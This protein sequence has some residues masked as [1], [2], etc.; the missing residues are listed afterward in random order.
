MAIPAKETYVNYQQ[1]YHN[2]ALEFDY[3]RKEKFSPT[4]IRRNQSVYALCNIEKGAKVLDVGS[5]RGWFSLYAA[6]QGADVTA[7]DLSEDNLQ[8][9]K[10]VDPRITTVYGDACD[11]P[12][13]DTKYDLIV[14]LEV[15]EHLVNPQAALLNWESL[16]KPGATLLITVPYK[17]TILYSLCIH[18]NKKTPYNAHLHSFDKA[19]LIKLLQESGYQITE[20]H[21]FLHKLLTLLR[22]NEITKRLPFCIWKHLDRL[23][24]LLGDKYSFIGIKASLKP[25]C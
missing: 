20:S 11:V 9:I 12:I 6:K 16:L 5:G 8:K 25:S 7:L 2:D 3:W 1:H 4:E 23:C 14:A 13:K 21:L 18:C 19:A 22:I 24:A 10:A 15:M 17:E